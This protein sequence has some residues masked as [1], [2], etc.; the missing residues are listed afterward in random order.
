MYTMQ[1]RVI[2]DNWCEIQHSSSHDDCTFEA[3]LVCKTRKKQQAVFVHRLKLQKEDTFKARISIVALQ[4]WIHRNPSGL[5]TD[6]CST[7]QL[8]AP[9][10]V[11]TQPSPE[12]CAP[13]PTRFVTAP[14]RGLL[15]VIVKVRPVSVHAVTRC[16]LLASLLFFF[17]LLPSWSIHRAKCPTRLPLQ[18]VS[19]S[20]ATVSTN[21]T[22]SDNCLFLSV[23]HIGRQFDSTDVA[24]FFAVR[25]FLILR[26]PSCTRSCT[27]KYRISF[28]VLHPTDPWILT[29]I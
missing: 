26:S 24:Q 16:T 10:R 19:L 2:V 18:R 25:T 17:S 13:S 8:R 7:N 3:R 6:A 29:F 11:P 20:F 12:I 14:C 15:E 23:L 28:W 4:V 27:Q 22:N 5:P 1:C 21:I 9:A